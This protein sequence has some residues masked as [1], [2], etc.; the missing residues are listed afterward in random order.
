MTHRIAIL[1]LA[2]QAGT[3]LD[4]LLGLRELSWSDPSAGLGFEYVLP[5]WLWVLI[6]VTG[7]LVAGWSYRRL[8][9]RRSLRVLLALVRTAVLLTIVILLAGPTLVLPQETIQRDWLMVLIDRSSS[10]RVQDVTDTVTGEPISRDQS[11]RDALGDQAEVFSDEGLGRDRKLVWL[12]FGTSAYTIGSPLIQPGLVAPDAPATSIRTAIEQA[13]RLP[14]GKPISGIVLITDG[15]TPQSTGPTLAQR[16][17]QQGVAVFPVPVG[18]A[19]PPLDLAIGQADGPQRAFLNDTAPVSVTVEQLGGDPVDPGEIHVA[20]IDQADDRVLDEQTL[21]Q[22]EPGQPLRLSGKSSTVGLARWQVRVTHKPP[23]G[24]PPIR[25]LVTENNTRTVEVEVIDRPIRVLYIEGYPRWEFRYLKNLLIREKSI[26]SST[27]LLSADRSFAQEGDVPITRPPADA[28]EMDAYDV[29]ILGDVPAEFFDTGQLTVLRDHVSAR[30]AGIIWIGGSQHTPNTYAG[31]PLAD[32][33]PMRRPAEVTRTGNATSLFKLEPTAVA[34]SLNVMRVRSTGQGALQADGWP[35]DLPP[36]RWVQNLGA[37]K[38]TAEV[39]AKAIQLEAGDDASPVLVRLRYGAGQSLYVG[40]DEA[41]RW[42]YGRGE[43]YFQQYW[44]QLIRMLGRARLQADTGR[45]HFRVSSRAVSVQQPVVV[46]LELSDPLLISRGIPRVAVSIRPA[47]DPTGPPVDSLD[48]LPVVDDEAVVPGAPRR[49]GYRALW[50][51]AASGT[52]M[53]T[54]TDPA[55]ADLGLVQTVRV[56]APDSEMLNPRSDHARLVNLAEQT[57]GA[58]VPLNE[59]DR[60]V[61]LVPNRARITP[62]DIREP[63]WD[64]ALSLIVL[65]VLFSFEWVVRRAIRLA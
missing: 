4:R 37:L 43:W 24:R 34:S 42:R 35:Q 51:P 38:P 32:L 16:L 39:I 28:Q 1:P 56:T 61:N 36:L 15:R 7:L 44:V 60:L 30:G 20:L 50:R 33:L 22:A 31:T 18:A 21:D 17:K 57:G 64:S 23:D 8:L 63:L 45:A 6:G 41:W 55:L 9:G 52:Q 65:M 48:L 53:L 11:V 27:Y 26:S 14:S 2:Q 58:V 54:V 25:E 47:S 13:L 12:G 3:L 19:K 59:M 49:I 5:A 10:M 29:V 40:T 62:T 46:E